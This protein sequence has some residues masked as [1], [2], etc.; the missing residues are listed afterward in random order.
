[1]VPPANVK[2][3]KRYPAVVC[4]HGGP[5]TQY[6]NKV[7]DEFQVYSGAGYAV[8]YCNPRGSSGYGEK[9][10]RW[11]RGPKAKEEPGKG[12]GTVDYDDVMAVVDEACKS[13]EF[14]DGD[15]LG[16]MGGSYGG[17]M[18]TWIVGHNDRF[19]AAISERAANNLLALEGHSDIATAFK[20]YYGVNHLEDPAEIARQSASSYV[21]Q[22]NTPM[23]LLHC[24]DDLRCP[25][26]QAEELFAG[27][28]LRQQE[29]ELVRF[30]GEGHE[31]SRSGA[32]KHRVERFEII[33]EFLAKHLA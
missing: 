23:L 14:I 13:F 22:I 7:F 1:M 15:R 17:Y 31:M 9:W 19:K 28:R 24:E 20:N 29:V 8:I 32:P 11:L 21:S 6:A 2:A 27:L 18:T 26:G 5:F 16:V 30:P 3:G 25:I 4:I 10:G 12:W 33:L